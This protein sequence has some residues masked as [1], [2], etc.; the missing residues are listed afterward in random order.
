MKRLIWCLL[1]LS[2]A[3]LALVFAFFQPGALGIPGSSAHVGTEAPHIEIDLVNN[4]TGWCDPLHIDTT[5][6]RAADG[7]PYQIAVC[8]SD[9]ADLDGFALPLG[10][11]QFDFIYN[12]ALNS[13]TDLSG[14][15]LDDNPDANDGATSFSTPDLGTGWDC[16]IQGAAPPV[17][18]KGGV[19]GRAFLKCQCVTTGG[20]CTSTLP[21]G[22]GV[23]APLAV[24]TLAAV[25]GGVDNLNLVNG[26]VFDTAA[27]GILDCGAA[28]G[29]P[30]YGATETKIGPAT[31]TFTPG[32]PTATFTAVPP[33][34][35]RTSTPVPP[36]ATFTPVPPTATFTPLPTATNTPL[37]TA[38]ATPLPTATAT[39]LPT[40]TATPLPTATA[41][42]LPTATNT[43]LPT[44]TATPLPTATNTPVPPTATNTPV[45]TATNTPVP[46]ATNTPLPPTATNTP[47]PTA[48]FTPVPP[49][50]TFTPVLPTAT[51]TPVPPTATFTPVPPTA[52]NTPVSPTKTN[53]PVPSA[54][55]TPSPQGCLDLN[56]DG[57]V[58][59][60]DI[61]IVARA[62]FSRLG[63]RRWN[64]AADV[65]G[66]E[67]VTLADLFLVIESSHDREC[68]K[69][70]H[71]WWR[72]WWW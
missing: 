16:N 25:A 41:T 54:T 34:P 2:V 72:F 14:S 29:P 44:A 21:T 22:A 37:P 3:G 13:C 51:F 63:D 53:T 8:L 52:T 64:P 67:K 43:P 61:S 71:H 46:T 66:D 24:V 27:G 4:G 55:G 70:A 57:K 12:P 31:P 23:S 58:D 19:A 65:N 30:C 20:V 50:A 11:F 56:D 17:C 9:A 26:H 48:T 45:P 10:A 7:T 38:T 42:P 68:K 39:P 49:T 36:T 32:A 28:G 1:A 15:A 35:T 59:G 60:R 47:V 40:A 18:A 33:T 6:S 62:L 5:A 69:P